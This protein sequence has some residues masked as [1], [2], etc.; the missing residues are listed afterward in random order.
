MR[1]EQFRL[2]AR[3]FDIFFAEK[4]GAFLNRFE[5][6]HATNLVLI[7]RMQ[8]LFAGLF[9]IARV[10]EEADVINDVVTGDQAEHEKR[11]RTLEWRRTVRCG[12]DMAN[13]PGAIS[14]PTDEEQ[15]KNDA[16]LRVRLVKMAFIGC[17]KSREAQSDETQERTEQQSAADAEQ[18]MRMWQR[19]AE[20]QDADYGEDD[21]GNC[22]AT[23]TQFLPSNVAAHAAINTPGNQTS[24][25][26]WHDWRRRH[27][28]RLNFQFRLSRRISFCALLNRFENGYMEKSKLK[29]RPREH[30]I[31][32]VRSK[33]PSS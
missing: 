19:Q 23:G 2:Q 20:K 33:M 12:D 7:R 9:F 32:V 28:R 26:N 8:S 4:S 3:R 10:D 22:D 16:N 15:R 1:E 31:V 11:Q 14:Q 24:K 18:Q 13:R 30:I 21:D 6:G 25:Q 27:G 29:F 17:F 5:D